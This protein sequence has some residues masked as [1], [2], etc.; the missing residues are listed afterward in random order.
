MRMTTAITDA[1][2]ESWERHTQAGFHALSLGRWREASDEWLKSLDEVQTAETSDARRPAALNNSGVASLLESRWS[3]AKAYFDEA[4]QAWTQVQLH[5]PELE[6]PVVGRS[7]SFHFRLATRHQDAFAASRRQRCAVLCRAALAITDFNAEL[8]LDAT[9]RS[10][11]SFENASLVKRALVDAFGPRCPELQ[12]IAESEGSIDGRSMAGHSEFSA[13]ALYGEKAQ[14]VFELLA[15]SMSAAL[16]ADY[17]RLEMA[18]NLT[19]LLSARLLPAH[20]HIPHH[21]DGSDE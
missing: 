20:S 1:S 7:S 21:L 13:A 10:S 16:S 4:R 11:P 9:G 5:I 14:R 18:T 17:R 2:L 8:A 6:V 12:L 19:A 3:D 15:R